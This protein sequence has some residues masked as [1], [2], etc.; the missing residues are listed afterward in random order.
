[1]FTVHGMSDS[2]NCYKVRRA[3]DQPR[4]VAMLR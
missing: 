2:G 4:C 3:A 1:M